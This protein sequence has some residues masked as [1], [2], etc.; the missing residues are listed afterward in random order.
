MGILVW[1]LLS[2]SVALYLSWCCRPFQGWSTG[3]EGGRD[4]ET[5]FTFTLVD[6]GRCLTM[7]LCLVGSCLD[8]SV[9]PVQSPPCLR[10]AGSWQAL[11]SYPSLAQISW[12]SAFLRLALLKSHWPSQW[13]SWIKI[14]TALSLVSLSFGPHRNTHQFFTLINSGSGDRLQNNYYFFAAKATGWYLLPSRFSG[15]CPPVHCVCHSSNKLSIWFSGSS[16]LF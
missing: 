16:F 9:A 1:K 8:F 13:S 3:K 11:W 2:F 6:P 14:K 12:Q 10:L 4:G 7:L 5:Y 15:I